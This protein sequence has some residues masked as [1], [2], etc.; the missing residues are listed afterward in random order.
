MS[1]STISLFA[2]EGKGEIRISGLFDFEWAWAGDA[3]FDLLHLEEAF[4]LHPD[5]EAAFLEG[6]GRRSMPTDPLRVYRILHGLKLFPVA[7]SS[8]TEPM[9]DLASRQE[10]IL[11]NLLK[12]KKPFQDT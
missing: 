4:D 8:K 2:F 7:L 10:A 6:Y 11:R 1:I 9:W 5:Y 12:D 3:P